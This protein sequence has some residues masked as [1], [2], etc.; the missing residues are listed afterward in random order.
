[1][2]Q[3]HNRPGINQHPAI[4]MADIR[5][6][7][8]LLFTLLAL[9]GC[10]SIGPSSCSTPE[11]TGRVL[12]AD[13][14]QPLAGVKVIRVLP[15]QNAA[16]STPACGAQLLQQGRSEMT[17][18]DGRFVVPGRQYVTLFRH[19]SW[20]SVRLAFQSPG[21]ALFQTNFSTAD[22]TNQPDAGAPMVNAG[23]IPLQPLARK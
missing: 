15:G 8:G 16:T 1:M 6:L 23:D 11:V 2:I 22:I 20:W 9:T 21:Y 14:Q 17:G 10:Q 18:A 3:K 7:A 19:A 13:T 4:K 12:A 5:L